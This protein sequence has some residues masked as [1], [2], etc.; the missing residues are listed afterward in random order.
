M[1]QNGRKEISDVKGEDIIEGTK[2]QVEE[3]QAETR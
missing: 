1:R 3:E 2:K